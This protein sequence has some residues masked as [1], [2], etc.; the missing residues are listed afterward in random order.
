[1]VAIDGPAGSGKSTIARLLAK[2]LNFRYLDT[3]AMY[4]VAALVSIMDNI[5][6]QKEK[7]LL[8]ALKRH[9]IAFSQDIESPK[10]LLDGEDV[11]LRIRTPELTRLVG[12]V[13]ELPAV[14]RFLGQ[15]QRRMGKGGGVVLEGRD[16]GTVIFPDA[17]VKIFLTASAPE[18]AKRRWQ[19]MV[20]NGLNEDYDDVLKDINERDLRDARRNL[21][22]LIKAD[23]ALQIDTTNL[24][25]DEVLDL[26]T[27]EVQ[28][29][30]R[31]RR[32]LKADKI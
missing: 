29:Y 19:E 20:K 30:L 6:P 3:G 9:K 27:A 12:P 26:V 17:E 14:R 4:R 25:I 22:P 18:R 24:T 5:P 16:I 15:L 11:S 21:A 23:D 31:P 28:K 2:R 1:V 32:D 8:S 7:E 10:I 13:C